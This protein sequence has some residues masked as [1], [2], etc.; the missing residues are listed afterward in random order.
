MDRTTLDMYANSALERGGR[1]DSSLSLPPSFSLPPSPTALRRGSWQVM[2]TV[3][4]IF[5]F[6]ILIYFIFTFLFCASW[7]VIMLTVAAL[8]GLITCIAQGTVLITQISSGGEP[9]LEVT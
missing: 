9:A 7:Q 5:C 2:L 3:T 4:T 8:F 1:K 6:V